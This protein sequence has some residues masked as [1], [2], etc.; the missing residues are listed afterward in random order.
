MVELRFSDASVSVSLSADG[1]KHLPLLTTLARSSRS[2]GVAVGVSVFGVTVGVGVVGVVGVGVGVELDGSVSLR[3][4]SVCC[5]LNVLKD[6]VF[7]CSLFVDVSVG[8]KTI[9]R[10]C[11][12]DVTECT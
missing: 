3:T 7:E 8:T 2:D 4:S 1:V 9:P 12:G 5:V 11:D 10:V 6:M